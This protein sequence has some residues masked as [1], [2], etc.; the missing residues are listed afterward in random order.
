MDEIENVSYSPKS[1]NFGDIYE[2]E[3]LSLPD[4]YGVVWNYSI[5]SK[6]KRAIIIMHR[7]LDFGGNCFRL[8]VHHWKNGVPE[9][10]ITENFY[11]LGKD[12]QDSFFWH[13]IGHIHFKHFL[14]VKYK[15]QDEVR[16]HR[17]EFLKKGDVLPEEIEADVFAV[18]RQG[19]VKYIRFLNF[20]KDTRPTAKPGSINDYGK[21]ELLL[22]IRKINDMKK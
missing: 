18:K 19:K 20:L 21:K 11:K 16:E 17:I 7:K 22:R 3:V 4:R 8:G 12:L 2:I 10:S 15:S 14:H 9:I 13:E 5:D 6:Q 1:S